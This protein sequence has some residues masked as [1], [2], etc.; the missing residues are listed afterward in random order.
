MAPPDFTWEELQAAFPVAT[1][2]RAQTLVRGEAVEFTR[3]VEDREHLVSEVRSSTDREM[4]TQD[5][6]L[7]RQKHALLID[8]ECSCPVGYNCKHVV[9][10]LMVWFQEKHSE[11]S[12]FEPDAA[13]VHSSFSFQDEKQV[14]MIR[15]IWEQKKEL[16][17]PYL[18]QLSA[19]YLRSPVAV[20]AAMGEKVW[21]EVEPL[22]KVSGAGPKKDT[23][24]LPPSFQL[25]NE[26]RL[27]LEESTEEPRASSH[28]LLF[29]LEV[30]RNRRKQQTFKI[31]TFVARKGKQGLKDIKP[32]QPGSS[33]AQ[34][35]VADLPLILVLGQIQD[36]EGL[37]DLAL[38]GH[39][40]TSL[41]ETGRLYLQDQWDTPIR[42]GAPREGLPVWKT[43][44][45]GKQHPVLQVNPQ[46]SVVLPLS[47]P[48]YLDYGTLELGPVDADLP[49]KDL[50]RFLSIP[51]VRMEHSSA[52]AE[53]LEERFGSR[54]PV[55]KVLPSQTIEAVM[56][57]RLTLCSDNLNLGSYGMG[58]RM[59]T[60]QLDW[61]YQGYMVTEPELP[62]IQQV[63]GGVIVTLPRDPL[64][65][66][67]SVQQLRKMGLEDAE[68]VYKTRLPERMKNRW[69]FRLQ[70]QKGAAEEQV[71]MD[72]ISVQVPMLKQQGWDIRFDPGFDFRLAEVG[73]WFADLEE[74]SDWF[75]LELG[76][77]V[78]EKR[79]SV[80]P[81]LMSLIRS[82]PAHV[83]TEQ[84][85]SLDNDA[86]LYP[87]LDNGTLLP[88]P[89]SRVRS[90]LGTLVELYSQEG[91]PQGK[92]RLP[93]L[94]AARLADLEKDLSPEWSGGTRARELGQKL[95]DFAGL[96]VA[97][98][99]AGLQAQ[100]RPYQHE[101]LN[102]L[103][104][105]REYGLNGILADDMGLGKTLQT[106]THLLLEKEQG[107][108]KSPALIVA[109]TSLMHNWAS[110]AHRF[111]PDLKVLV[112]QGT[113]RKQDFGRISEHDL[114]LTTYPL[115]SR[116]FEVL[117]Q[118][119]FHSIILDE[120]QNI[121]N[122]KSATSKAIGLLRS[123]H[124]LCLTG[125]PLENH[126]GE[127]WSLFHFL[128]P[129][130]LGDERQFA[131]LYR[132]PIEKNADV[133]RRAAL[134][135]R[136]RPFI[137]RR[138]KEQ[139]AKELPEKT[140]MV[141]RLDL[142]GAQRDLYET[143]R[144]SVQK[145]VQE[146][147]ASRGLARS[148]IAI[149]DALLKLRQVCCDP[150]LLS[151]DAAKK[152]RHSIKLDWFKETL[153]SMIEEGRR[154]LVFSQFATLLGLLEETLKD[155]KIPYSKITGDTVDR[156]TQIEQF[157]SGQTHM[158]LISLKA[159]GVGLNL[160]A[161][162]TVI[163]YDPWW[164]PA[165]ENQATDRAYRIGQDKP[166]F[167]YKLITAGT[168]EEKILDLQ[169]RKAALA[170]GILEGGLGEGQTLTLEDVQALFGS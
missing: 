125:T 104:F 35:V 116:D 150:R 47:K 97:P 75:G 123:Q 61:T 83:L 51:P 110:E 37:R 149:L 85:N 88:L 146:E 31:R 134:A 64:A 63:H 157:Q 106:L 114:V 119:T 43:A 32:Y 22:L 92:V 19:L 23:D 145:R 132:N 117:S 81:L 3:W 137:L 100:L 44:A 130:F 1:W 36:W 128:M 86:M 57:P 68:K 109:P 165:A 39:I 115:I 38:T 55:P 161:A 72:F 33:F 105:L 42:A 131:H 94:D 41:L 113:G 169:A 26:L 74:G 96:Q 155:L 28:T 78:G 170:Q 122:A 148:H 107:R 160:T 29:G 93:L 154:V 16:K 156:K 46:A 162:D 163:H 73:G 20:V 90:L 99:P 108:L 76:V 168:L 45:D 77:M 167:V 48:W 50:Q 9:A 124:R 89:I 24:L 153:P 7:R 158:F 121:K 82:M 98:L 103:Q 30:V 164:N 58:Q 111:T 12:L 25:P 65:E 87:R 69:G 102:W 140:E 21:K 159:G 5:I 129:G 17:E 56:V 2:S 40:L 27:W 59:H 6:L 34:Y 118:H 10:A 139:V 14:G 126:L 15:F 166:V 141:V 79:I 135:K 66:Q 91:L 11:E 120:A 71:W 49:E 18:S 4:Y 142:E 8:G 144:I 52:F 67:E 80:L 136:I 101:G 13:P 53:L 112:L 152:V 54:F 127:L 133:N 95:R 147:I 84:L 151:L 70:K 62:A 60:V 143:L 138:T